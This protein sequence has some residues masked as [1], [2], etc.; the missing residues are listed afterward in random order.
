MTTNNDI[1]IVFAFKTK[2]YDKKKFL[3]K[4]IVKGTKKRRILRWFQ[5]HWK[6]FKKMH[7]KKV[8]RK[9]N[10]MSISKSSL[11]LMFIKFV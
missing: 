7:K 10:L 2:K 1:K 8:I 6:S 4:K 11:W 9:T 3:K 5:I